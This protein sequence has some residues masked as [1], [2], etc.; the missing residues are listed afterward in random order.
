[1]SKQTIAK[2]FLKWA[3]GKG[4]LMHEIERIFPYGRDEAFTFIEP[5]AASG[6]VLF[7][8]LRHFPNI[9][10]AIINDINTD[11]TNTYTCID[12]SVDELIALLQQLE[13]EFH[14]LLSDDE[15]K[16]AYYYA[17]R[18]QF[19]AREAN[20]IVQ[21]ALFIFLNRT[22]FNG[23]YRVNKR[24][25]F[26][27]PIGRYK[28]P[29]ICHAVNLRAASKALQKVTILNGDFE[30]TLSYA[31]AKTCFYLDPPYKPLNKTS[32]FNAYAHGAFDDDEQVR[33]QQFC[34][35]I[36]QQGYHWILSNSD[37]KHTD[38]DNEFF[39]DLYADFSIARI[40]ARRNINSKS[41]KRGVISELLVSNVQS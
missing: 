3:G 15:K 31:N 33:L 18:E 32:S 41:R 10:S 28:K 1:M 14:A 9:Q 17:K 19:N 13:Q 34:A 35:S 27:V 24:N 38:P 22:C 39:D 6:A 2:P 12:H 25:L 30:K 40:Q 4:Q 20:E 21:S 29:T 16:K 23:L 7:W 37:L 11:L 5:F 26:N 36:D 8:V